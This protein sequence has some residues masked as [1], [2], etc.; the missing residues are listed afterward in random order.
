MSL[1]DSRSL[2]SKQEIIKP[3]IECCLAQIATKLMSISMISDDDYDTITDPESS[4]SKRHLAEIF[5]TLREVV[6]ED[7]TKYYTILDILADMGPPI[8]T[9][10]MSISA[11]I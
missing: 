9:A 4:Q 7:Y 8:S 6:K 11:D 5:R 10:V 1:K 3:C 2:I